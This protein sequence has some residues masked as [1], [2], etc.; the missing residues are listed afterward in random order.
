MKQVSIDRD[1]IENILSSQNLGSVISSEELKS[2]SINPVFLINDKYIL[3][4]DTGDS[5]N[6]DK[7]K[8]EA[9]LFEVLSKFSIPVPKII[10]FD[11]SCRLIKYPYILMSNIEGRDLKDVF[12]TQKHE[13]QNELSSELGALAKNIHAISS[14]DLGNAVIF[15]D[16]K[17]WVDNEKENF[18]KYWSSIKKDNYFSKDICDKVEKIF[19][20]YQKLTNWEEVGRLTHGD[21]SCGNI[22]VNSG[23]IVGVFDFEFANIADP[24][25]DLQKLPIAFQLGDGFDKGLFLENYMTREFT[26]QEI[27][28]LKMY[29]ITQGVWEIWACETQQFP[30]GQKEIDEGKQ[31]ITNTIYG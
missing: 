4:I 2:G 9:M 26:I 5:E 12:L 11:D 27:T 31:L 10:V 19:S 16:I 14:I 1:E 15:G 8:K 23:H 25:Y 17:S 3:R 6:K 18:R 7:F 29:C 13:T 30:Y 21:F 24:L 22:K 28:R 20:D